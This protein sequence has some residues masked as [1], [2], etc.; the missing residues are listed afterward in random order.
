MNSKSSSFSPSWISPPGETIFDL[1]EKRQMS[2]PTLAINI[3]QSEGETISLL[4]GKAELTQAIA[5]HLHVALGG[6]TE[7][8]LQREKQYRQECLR[9]NNN[10]EDDISWLNELPI[11]DLVRSK[12]IRQVKDPAQRVT[13]CLDFFGVPSVREWREK[14]GNILSTAAF[15]TSQTFTPQ[16]GATAAWLRRGTIEAISATC[17]YWSKTRFQALLPSLRELSRKRRPELFVPELQRRCAECGVVVVI[18]RSPTGCRASGATLFVSEKR[19]L[20]LLS[21]R[22][23]SDDHFWFTFFHESAHLVLHGR[24]K[25]FIEQEA[26]SSAE[27]QEANEFAERMLIPE[28][29]LDDFRHLKLQDK[30]VIRF[31][32]NI[33]ISPGVVVGQLQHQK[34]LRPNQLNHLKTRFAWID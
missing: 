2:L 3:S 12:W 16:L 10:S 24:N 6:S 23:L 15:R 18:N 19:A 20:L 4:Q 32:R 33:G 7:F 27:E 31:A 26:L 22:Y 9:L 30:E 34:R 1:M 5:E 28:D 25:V 11:A 8:W 13:E 21:F 29:A 17:G 14:Y